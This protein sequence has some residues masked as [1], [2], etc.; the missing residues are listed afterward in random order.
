MISLYF[1]IPFPE[2]LPD[3]IFFEKVRQIEWLSKKGMLGIKKI[4]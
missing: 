1:H 4:E 2:E 3:N